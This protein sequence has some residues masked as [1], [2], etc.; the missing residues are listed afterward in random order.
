MVIVTASV[1]LVGGYPVQAVS[2]QP[3]LNRFQTISPEIDMSISRLNF[4]E[5]RGNDKLW[6][7]D[8]RTGGF[9]IRKPAPQACR[10]E[11]GNIWR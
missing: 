1:A 11:N 6:D 8:C 4:S 10:G 5:M 9:M 7:F 3:R 2:V